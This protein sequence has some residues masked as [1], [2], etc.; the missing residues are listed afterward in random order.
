MKVFASATELL[1]YPLPAVTSCLVS[2][3]RLPRLSGFDLQAELGRLGNNMPIIC[4]T[5]HGDV[6]MSVKAMK[7]GR[8]RSS[9]LTKPFREQDMYSTRW[10]GTRAGPETS[11]RREVRFRAARTI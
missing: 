9:F 1:E 6:P 2:D 4:I 7:E 8:R 3:I 11:H 10:P 5:G